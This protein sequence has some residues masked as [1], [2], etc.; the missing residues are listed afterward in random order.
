[1]TGT[2][3]EYE[4]ATFIRCRKCQRK[5]VERWRRPGWCMPCD[6]RDRHEAG[7]TVEDIATYVDLPDYVVEAV[8]Q[9]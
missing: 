4:S 2:T 8:L 6:V 5:H 9:R 3:W 1:M 7:G